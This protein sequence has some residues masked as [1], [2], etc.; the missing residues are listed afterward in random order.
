[1][2]SRSRDRFAID[3]TEDYEIYGIDPN[4]DLDDWSF[5][6]AKPEPLPEK[7]EEE[8]ATRVPVHAVA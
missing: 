7:T 1:M 8:H 4:E 6:D 3:L 5:L 2:S